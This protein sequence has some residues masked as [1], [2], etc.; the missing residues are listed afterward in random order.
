M[1]IIYHKKDGL[2]VKFFL[3]VE[4]KNPEAVCSLRISSWGG[5]NQPSLSTKWQK[6]S[7]SYQSSESKQTIL[8]SF[9]TAPG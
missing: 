8:P 4:K 1:P 3:P 9:S 6:R 7:I 2:S 5:K